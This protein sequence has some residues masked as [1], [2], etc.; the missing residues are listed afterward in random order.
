M[1]DS[2]ITERGAIGTLPAGERSSGRVP[3][4]CRGG[5]TAAPGFDDEHAVVIE[6]GGGVGPVGRE[7]AGCAEGPA[8]GVPQLS[9][10]DGEAVRVVTVAAH[11]EDPSVAKERRTV[12]G[13]CL[14]E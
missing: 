1:L 2:P 12:A 14:S 4:L 10:F 5:P 7:R 8:R 9:G 6:Q 3:Q 13:A 11:D